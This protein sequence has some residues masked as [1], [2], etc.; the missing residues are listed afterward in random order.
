MKTGLLTKLPAQVIITALILHSYSPVLLMGQSP[1]NTLR[2]PQSSSVG[3]KQLSLSKPEYEIIEGVFHDGLGTY[4]ELTLANELI[5]QSHLRQPLFDTSRSRAKMLDAIDRL[6]ATHLS[7][8]VFQKEI[9]NIESAAL[10]GAVELLNK[11]KSAVLA[12]VSHVATEYAGA[13]AGDIRLEFSNHPDMPVSVKTDKSGKVAVAEGQTPDIGA[14]WAS[15][16]FNVSEEELDKMILNS[17]Y[18]SMAD[19]KSYY[20]NVARLVARIIIHKLELQ[21]CEPTDFSRARVGNLEAVKYLFRQLL[22]FKKGSD[23]SHIIIFD[24]ATGEVVWESL[25]DSM[26]IDRLTSDRVSFLPSRPRGGRVIGSEFGIRVDGRTIVSFQIKHK[27]GRQR[28]T[29]RQYEFSDITTR[30]RTR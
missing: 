19:L 22:K 5:K 13:K 18:T 15:R 6:P 1:A 23:G 24:R 29:A 20:L 12:R 9:L 21:Q 2:E 26:D 4:A 7:R 16:Y 10:K 14:K 3:G 27:R 11:A 28:G 30:L 17:G 25:L 8:V